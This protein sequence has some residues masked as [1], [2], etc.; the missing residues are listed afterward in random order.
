[1]F[2][3]QSKHYTFTFSLFFWNDLLP[4]LPF[5][6]ALHLYI[7]IHE[8]DAVT[9]SETPAIESIAKRLATLLEAVSDEI[10]QFGIGHLVHM[11]SHIWK[12][13]GRYE[14]AAR[15]NLRAITMAELYYD[16]FN[17][18]EHSSSFNS[19]HRNTYYCHRI[20]FVIYASMI[21]G[22]FE[23]ADQFAT[24]LLTRCK[25]AISNVPFFFENASWRNKNALQFGKWDLILQSKDGGEGSHYDITRDIGEQQGYA[26]TM[27]AFARGFAL[28]SDGQ[29]ESARNVYSNEFVPRFEND[30]IRS[31]AIMYIQSAGALLEVARSSLMARIAEKCDE[32]TDEAESWWKEAVR[33]SDSILYMEPP[34]WMLSPRCCLGQLYLDRGE[35]EM[36]EKKFESDLA[37]TPRNG[38]ALRGMIDAL[39]GRRNKNVKVIRKYE[40]QFEKAWKLS[41]TQIDRACY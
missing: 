38:W 23:R 26:Q 25:M 40:K 41:D 8:V 9:V 35:Y 36:A 11:P 21:S 10:A 33:H 2:T 13:L 37:Y 24:K 12:Q 32:N 28:A 18:S 1:M 27:N 29:C 3:T 20:T 39:K 31:I 15:V 19:F 30:T 22:Q 14:K 34:F 16:H 17:I 6:K 4:P 7:H 5:V